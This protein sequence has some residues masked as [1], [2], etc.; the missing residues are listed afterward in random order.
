MKLASLSILISGMLA[1]GFAAGQVPDEATQRALIQRQRSEAQAAYEQRKAKCTEAFAVNACEDKARTAHRQET[2]RLR[3]QELAL[4]DAARQRKTQANR[5]RLAA[6]AAAV[7]ASAS[8]PAPTPRRPKVQGAVATP[9]ESGRAPKAKETPRV[10]EAANRERF[11]ARQRQA[12]A[13]RKT[14]E[15]RN[16]ERAAKRTKAQPLPL[17]PGASRP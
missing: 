6:K 2:R 13:H 5:E 8:A 14:V 7:D 1:A 17:P 3:E 16:A 9:R 12:Q 11:E 15:Q 10:D 4:D